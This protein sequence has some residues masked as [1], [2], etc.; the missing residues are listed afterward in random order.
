M[1]RVASSP[2]IRG[3]EIS[4]IVSHEHTRSSAENEDL[5]HTHEHIVKVDR[6]GRVRFESFKTVHRGAV[7]FLQLSKEAAKDL[8]SC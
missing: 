2:S 1:R 7:C 3:I 8:L 6:R 5:W 4:G